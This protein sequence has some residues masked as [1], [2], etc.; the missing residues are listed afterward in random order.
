[1][2]LSFCLMDIMEDHKHH[3]LVL[4]E[5]SDVLTTKIHNKMHAVCLRAVLV[6][7]N[8]ICIFVTAPLTHITEM[9]ETGQTPWRDP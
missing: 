8:F 6:H 4:M 7:W 1:M 9:F 2:A 3:E 5:Q